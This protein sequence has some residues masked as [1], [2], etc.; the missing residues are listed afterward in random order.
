MREKSKHEYLFQW[1]PFK[2]LFLVWH[3]P[4]SK[5]CKKHCVECP[6]FGMWNLTN[7]SEVGHGIKDLNKY[8]NSKFNVEIQ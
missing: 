8:S 7:K 1:G 3:L 4:Y 6:A 2:K 5:K